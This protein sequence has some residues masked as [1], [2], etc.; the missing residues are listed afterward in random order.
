MYNLTVDTAHTFFVGEGQWLVHNACNPLKKFGGETAD[1][2]LGK[3][4]HNNYPEILGD[5]DLLKF[6]RRIKGTNL[7]PDYIDLENRIV[8]ELKPDKPWAINRGLKQLQKYMNELEKLTGDSWTGI[9]DLY[10]K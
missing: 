7:R 9:L 10:P 1:T 4:M 5:P 2:I 3:Q 8:R 6:N